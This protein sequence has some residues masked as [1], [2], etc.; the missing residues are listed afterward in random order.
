MHP[1][2]GR[3]AEPELRRTHDLP[4]TRLGLVA[5]AAALV[6][7]TAVT[8][9]IRYDS[10]AG[11][12]IGGVTSVVLVAVLAVRLELVVRS[13]QV[14]ALREVTVRDA[15]GALGSSRDE[16]AIREVALWARCRTCSASGSATWPGSA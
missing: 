7:L 13:S 16:A 12:V 15:A 4:R 9:H 3:I 2:A 11:L 5:V 6:P 1:S 8:Q 14:Q 10:A